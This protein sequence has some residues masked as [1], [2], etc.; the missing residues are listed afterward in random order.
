MTFDTLDTYIEYLTHLRVSSS[1]GYKA[2]HKA[3]LMITVAELIRDGIITSPVIVN[4]EVLRNSFTKNW[5]KFIQ[6]NTPFIGRIDM[7]FSHIGSEKFVI[8]SSVYSFEIDRDL[9]FLMQDQESSEQIISNLVSTYLAPFAFEHKVDFNDINPYRDRTL[10]DYQ[11]DGKAKIYKM[12]TQMRSIMYQ[13]PT[14]TGKTKLF[15][16]IA[17]DLFDWGAAHKKSVKIL[18]LAHRIELIDQISENLGVKYHLAHG[19]IASQ[20]REQKFYG[21]QV[22]SVQTLVRRL[23]KWEDKEFDFVIIDEA[24]HVKADSYKKI[25][26]SFPKAKVLGVTA[27]PYRMSHDSFRPEFDE[28]ITSMPVS[29]F[30]KLKWLCDYEYYS[31]RPESKIQIDINSISRFAL[32]GDYLDEASAAV[33][34]K[35]EIR[36]NIVSTYERYAKGKKGIVYTITKAHN[37]HVCEQYVQRGY[38]AV[39]ID[40]KTPAATRKQYVEDFKKGKIDIICNV[41]IFSEGFDCP[42]LEFIQLARPT[43]SLSMYLQQVGR[44]LRPA[45]GKEMLIILDN[46]GLYNRFGFPSARRQW[47]KHFEGMYVEYSLPT[48][49]HVVDGR[50]VS[51]IDDFDEGNEDVEMLHTTTNEEIID[52][53]IQPN[54]IIIGRSNEPEFRFYLKKI[55]FKDIMITKIVRGIKADVDPI[56][57]GKYN[58][59]HESVLKMENISELELYLYDF[60]VNPVIAEINSV[61]NKTMTESLAHYINYLKWRSEEGSVEIQNTDPDEIQNAIH[62]ETPPRTIEEVEMEIKILRKWGKDVP[63]E[64]LK[65]YKSLTTR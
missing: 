31:I 32:D 16:S 55:G 26:K 10:R 38:R 25:L 60:Q 36:A 51:F 45:P 54:E 44:G 22:G 33:M 19:L 35:D 29:K 27:T 61:K 30:I 63:K 62:E 64:L 13:M 20:N 39:A 7:P 8:E 11:S 53:V 65:E 6:I 14:G 15:V 2:P 43:K 37:Q 57:K 12:W 47:R 1:G 41:N 40:D 3:V 17:R 46:V 34:D 42:D 58:S 52:D 18:F 9:F 50:I 23:D 49:A 59:R 56:I 5:L 24:H 4:D 28:L 21:L 48:G